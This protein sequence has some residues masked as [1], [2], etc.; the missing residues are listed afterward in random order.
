MPRLPKGMVRKRHAFYLRTYTKGDETWTPLGSDYE[1][2]CA[3]LK[4]LRERPIVP[5][6]GTV[7]QVADRWL[8]AYVATARNEKGGTSQRSGRVTS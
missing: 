3:R 2:A 8:S 6:R 5:N 1:V 7:S 4:Q